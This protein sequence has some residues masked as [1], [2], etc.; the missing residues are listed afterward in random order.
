MLLCHRERHVHL[1]EDI[2]DSRDQ[3]LDIRWEE[4]ANCSEPKAVG[5]GELARIDDETSVREGF[6]EPSEVKVFV[7][8]EE[9]CRDDDALSILIQVWVEAQL[10]HAFFED[11]E[12]GLI[13]GIPSSH[14]TLCLMP[15][16]SLSETHQS[17][18]WWGESE[19]SVPLEALPLTHDVEGE[20]SSMDTLNL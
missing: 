13:S 4:A 6:I 18:A 20:G 10:S 9:E 17:M 5:L 8:R 12:I 2:L 1:L 14:A 3:G 19:L 11:L 7:I 16:E 15:G